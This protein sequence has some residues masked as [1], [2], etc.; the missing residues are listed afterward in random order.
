MFCQK[1][2]STK[3]LISL[4]NFMWY[5]C[6]CYNHDTFFKTNGIF[7]PKKE[8]MCLKENV[9]CFI[10]SVFRL[11]KE[12][13]LKNVFDTINKMTMW[14]C[15]THVAYGHWQWPLAMTVSIFGCDFDCV[16]I[17][18]TYRWSVRDAIVI[19]LMS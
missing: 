11:I 6:D 7:V 13:Q 10:E 1:Y 16:R 18:N 9:F 19:R 15:V 17:Y 3:C 12:K 5:L 2:L 14:T 8:W 4:N